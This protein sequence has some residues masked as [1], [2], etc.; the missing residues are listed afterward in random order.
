MFSDSWEGLFI[1]LLDLIVLALGAYVVSRLRS[2]SKMLKNVLTILRLNGIHGTESPDSH[3]AERLAI[4]P[5]KPDE[6]AKRGE[7]S[8]R[9]SE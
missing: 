1:H 5:A 6:Q 9:H 4:H 8:G 7:C 2:N 3:D